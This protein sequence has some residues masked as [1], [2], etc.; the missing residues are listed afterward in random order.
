VAEAAWLA[1]QGVTELFLVSEN[2]TSYGKDLAQPRALETLLAQLSRLDGI[3]WI[4]LSY[5]QPAEVRPSLIEAIATTDKVV[6]YF[7]LP[8]QHASAA[9]LRRMRRFGDAESFLG[10][11]ATVRQAVPLAGIRSNVIVGFPGETE[12][13]VEALTQF[14]GEARL[15]AVGVFAYSDEEGTA[16]ADLDGHL[17]PDEIRARTTDVA[18]LADTVC[19]LRAQER[20]GQV[21]Q[22]L[23]EAVGAR[24]WTGRAAQQG[25]DDGHTSG[26]GW[27][28]G[29]PSRVGEILTGVVVDSAGVDWIVQPTG[30]RAGLPARGIGAGLAM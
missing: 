26:P 14:L 4:R 11:L 15:D 17:D 23:V 7:D 18:M 30:G 6:P 28:T 13:D 27:G 21:A 22:V 5:L 1:S 9:V 20:V 8:F 19:A 16:A 25:P 10:L 3:D 29:A 2:T 24:G 12:A